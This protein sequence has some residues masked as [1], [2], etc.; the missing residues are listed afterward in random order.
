MDEMGLEVVTGAEVGTEGSS[1]PWWPLCCAGDTTILFGF[2]LWGS[3]FLVFSF[4]TNNAEL[5]Q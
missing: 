3:H 1:A 4:F 5:T 2:G